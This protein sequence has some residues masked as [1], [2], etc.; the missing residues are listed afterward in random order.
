MVT[1]EFREAVMEGK[2]L[3][4]RIMLKDSLIIDPTCT[5]F[6]EMLSYANKHLPDLLVPFDGENLEDDD[7]KWN[8]NVMNEELIQ[9]VTNFSEE[10]INHL[11]KVVAKVLESESVKIR[12]KK[13]EQN[14]R[15]SFLTQT[16]PKPS[17]KPQPG[18]KINSPKEKARREALKMIHK[19]ARRIGKIITEVESCGAWKSANID[20]IEQAAKEILRAVKEYKDNRQEV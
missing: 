12:S 5:Q 2:L 3:R 6:N 11:Q 4:A 20:E 10:R 7:S 8:K 17:Y 13:S 18:K 14:R 1:T 16:T 9:L 19:V 15:Q